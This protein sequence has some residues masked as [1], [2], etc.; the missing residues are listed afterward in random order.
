MTTERL[1][2]GV[3][4]LTC[5]RESRRP[6]SSRRVESPAPPRWC[7]SSIGF[8]AR[9]WKSGVCE[10]GAGAGLA[11][12]SRAEAAGASPVTAS[13]GGQGPSSVGGAR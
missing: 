13:W 9:R 5:S 2:I 12:D 6:R 11:T 8:A 10:R 1:V 3:T 4:L 7:A